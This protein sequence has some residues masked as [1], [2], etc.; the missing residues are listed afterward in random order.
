MPKIIL[1][2]YLC[3]TFALAGGALGRISFIIFVLGLLTS[4]LWHNIVLWILIALQVIVNAI[5]II[6]LFIQCPGHQS[7]I[8]EHSN[9]EKCWN[10]E[11]Q[12][13]YGY[14]QG[15][16][17]NPDESSNLKDGLS[18]QDTCGS[19]QLSD[20]PISG[21]VLDI[22][23]LATESQITSSARSSGTSQF[24]NFVSTETPA[25]L[26][27]ISCG[28]SIQRNGC[29]HYQNHPNTHPSDLQH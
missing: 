16:K 23:F 8:W 26:S 12:A 10:T 19:V 9:K 20:R 13:D 17:I 3:Q 18:S 6:I 28:S 1:L 21:I 5:F 4:R 29:S 14:F 27:K 2:D 22:R 25:S 7:A 15:G 11:I 24:R